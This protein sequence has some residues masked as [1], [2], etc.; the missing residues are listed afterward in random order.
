M[1][2]II[3]TADSD[4]L[5]GTPSDDLIDTAGGTDSVDPAAIISTETRAMTRSKAVPA[6][7]HC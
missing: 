1:A 3:G 2:T 5:L 7:T 4:T 6:T